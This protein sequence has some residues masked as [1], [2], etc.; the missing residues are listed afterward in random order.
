MLLRRLPLF[1][2]VLPLLLIGLALLR[3]TSMQIPVGLPGDERYLS[4]VL[5]AERD[6]DQHPFRWTT[7]ETLLWLHGL[8]LNGMALALHLHNF[9]TSDASPR[10]LKVARGDQPIGTF[11]MAVGWRY[12]HILLPRSALSPT[13]DTEPIALAADPPFMNGSDSQVRGVALNQLRLRPFTSIALLWRVVVYAWLLAVCA[14]WLWRLDGFLLKH[15]TTRRVWRVGLVVAGA[16]LLI[17]VA[18]WRTPLLL[19]WALPALPWSLGVATALLVGLW[20]DWRALVGRWA[21]PLALILLI[22]GQALLVTQT[23]VPLGIGLALLGMLLMRGQFP[24]HTAQP[25]ARQEFLLLGALLV[26]A[27]ALRFYRITELPYGLWR[28]EGRH[29]LAA[30]QMLTDP[31]YRPAYIA[32]GV[33]LPGLGLAPFALPIQLWGIHAWTLR[34]LT[35]LAGALTIVPL[36]GLVR[37]LFGRADLALIAAALLAVSHWSIG[38]SRFSFPTIFDPLLQLTA[39]WLMLVGFAPG[40]PLLR[41][42]VLIGAGTALGLAAQTYH[43]G[44]IGPIIAGIVALIVLLRMP[45]AWRSWM[46]RVAIVVVMCLVVASPLLTY[47]IRR[48]DAFNE[49][50]GSVFI[51]SP[52]ASDR[53]GPLAKLDDALGRH[54]LMFNSRGDSNGRHIAPDRAQLDPIAGLGLLAGLAMLLRA[55]TD[56]RAQVVVAGLL[57]GVLPSALAVDSPHAMRSVDSLGFACVIAAL[58]FVQIGQ[59]LQRLG[60]GRIALRGMAT[61][62]AIAMLAFSSWLYFVQMPSDPAV[63]GSGYPAHTQV[64]TYLRD[65]ADTE[66]V[67]ALQ[68]VF[69][70]QGMFSNPVLVFLTIGLPVQHYSDQ[71]LDSDAGPGARLVVPFTMTPEQVAA[72]ATRYQLRAP[73]EVVGPLLPD[74]SRPVFVVYRVRS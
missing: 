59:V 46:W 2:A 20:R 74:E 19:A 50:V 31:T 29:G 27:L 73:P 54:L 1:L 23:A 58:G 62:V 72:L 65:I 42:V 25:I 33:D 61:V 41:I 15:R 4:N 32:G 48:A 47:A 3:P 18:A 13:L 51:L 8:D 55:R 56:W 53:R 22:A 12:Y 34:T 68:S 45:G 40:R 14:A 17:A 70:P 30:F 67:Q 38:L 11:P 21:D 24:D 44:R 43:T 5:G 37:R 69:V 28:D 35:A 10:S 57:V 63:W 7:P 6:T 16:G 9:P 66:G 52:N 60:F 36:Y 39:L 71:T 49:R 64:G 26:V